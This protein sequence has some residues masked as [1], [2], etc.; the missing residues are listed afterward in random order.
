VFTPV[1]KLGYQLLEP[2]A[3]AIVVYAGAEDAARARWVRRAAAA[4]SDCAVDV[5]EVVRDLL[6]NPQIRIVVFDGD[7]MNRLDWDVFWL[8]RD[9]PDWKIDHEH[10]SLVRQ[11]VDLF[12]EDFGIKGPLQPFWPV[13]IRYLE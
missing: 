10:L 12:D 3:Q 7:V 4:I 13:R 1:S 8:G 6:A 11:F 2:S 5:R 9:F